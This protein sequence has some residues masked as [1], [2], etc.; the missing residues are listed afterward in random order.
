M[1]VCVYIL[2]SGT[3]SLSCVFEYLCK[4]MYLFILQCEVKRLDDR[5]VLGHSDGYGT[6]THFFTHGLFE[7]KTVPEENTST[8]REK[9]QTPYIRTGD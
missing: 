2:M 9:K 1:L 8:D 5:C 7:E 4:N 6:F 3:F